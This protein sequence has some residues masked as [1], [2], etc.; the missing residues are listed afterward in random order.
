M[1]KSYGVTLTKATFT[2][3]RIFTALQVVLLRTPPGEKFLPRRCLKLDQWLRVS[4]TV[5][6]NFESFSRLVMTPTA[7]SLYNPLKLL[8]CAACVFVTG[9]FVFVDVCMC[10]HSSAWDAKIVTG[11]YWVHHDQVCIQIF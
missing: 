4:G 5:Q 2:C 11:A 6:G 10:V 1:S 9:V 3:T 8:W 7:S